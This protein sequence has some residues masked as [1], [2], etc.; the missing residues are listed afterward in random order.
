MSTLHQRYQ[1]RLL[2]PKH[3]AEL[4]AEASPPLVAGQINAPLLY[5]RQPDSW[6]PS[7]Y[8]LSPSLFPLD[9]SK[10][11][12]FPLPRN[13]PSSRPCPERRAP[14]TCFRS[15]APWP[16]PPAGHSVPVPACPPLPCAPTRWPPSPRRPSGLRLSSLPSPGGAAHLWAGAAHRMRCLQAH[17]W[18]DADSAAT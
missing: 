9:P 5:W 17:A 16:S 4:S 2:L 13:E 15:S 10:A 3:K 11:A 18:L 8:L 12:R 6:L 14:H 1:C 7:A